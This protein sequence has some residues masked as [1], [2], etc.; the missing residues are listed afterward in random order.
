VLAAN[1]NVYGL[2]LNARYCAYNSAHYMR[3]F[4][5]TT[6]VPDNIKQSMYIFTSQ[7]VYVYTSEDNTTRYWREQQGRGK[8]QIAEE[9]NNRLTNK[10]VGCCN[11]HLVIRYS[12]EQVDDSPGR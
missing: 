9:L 5:D 4:H 1:V 2:Y 12:S 11:K 3:K 10:K 7:S 6:S 8:L